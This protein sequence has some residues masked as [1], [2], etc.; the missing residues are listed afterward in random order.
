MNTRKTF[1]ILKFLVA[2]LGFEPKPTTFKGCY[3][4]PLHHKAMCYPIWI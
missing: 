1:E 4:K 2:S 3:A